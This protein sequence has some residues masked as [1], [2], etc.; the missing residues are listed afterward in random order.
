LVLSPLLVP[1]L[2]ILRYTCEKEVFFLTAFI[3]MLKLGPPTMFQQDHLSLNG[4]IFKMI[5]FRTMTDERDKDGNLLSGKFRLTE[6]GKFLRSTSLDGL[7]GLWSVM[8]GDMSLVGP[9]PFLI[10]YLPLYS[11]K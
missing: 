4:K 11:K 6:F 8:K 7:P 10:E 2:I 9:H 3:V 1:L 5:K